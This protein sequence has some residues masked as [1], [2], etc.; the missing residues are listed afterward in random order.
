M[1]NFWKISKPLEK[2]S[3]FWLKIQIKSDW[4]ILIGNFRKLIWKKIIFQLNLIKKFES[5]LLIS[6]II[7][8]YYLI[9][10]KEKFNSNF[11]KI[12]VFFYTRN[13]FC[14]I[15]YFKKKSKLPITIHTANLIHVKTSNWSIKNRFINILRQGEKGTNGT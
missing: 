11:R 6:G 12:F 15:K 4:K 5:K 1:R 13:F 9:F 8:N 7:E 14:L 2:Y 10:L 3:E